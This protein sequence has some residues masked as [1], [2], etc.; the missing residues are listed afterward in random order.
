VDFDVCRKLC[1]AFV[2]RKDRTT[3]NTKTTKE[4]E[5]RKKKFG[6]QKP[7]L[8]VL[9]GSLFRFGVRWAKAHPTK[10]AVRS[11]DVASVAIAML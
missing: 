11:F 3:K 8:R 6:G 9:R 1:R 2:D 7:V 4:E 10:I 5:E